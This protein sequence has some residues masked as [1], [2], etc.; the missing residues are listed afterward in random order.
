[1]KFNALF[2]KKASQ[3]SYTGS[4]ESP[5]N[6][7]KIA[8]DGNNMFWRSQENLKLVGSN[9]A[10]TEQGEGD[11]INK[12]E[13]VNASNSKLATNLNSAKK[14]SWKRIYQVAALNQKREECITRKRKPSKEEIR[15]LC[16]EFEYDDGAKILK[17]EEVADRSDVRT[18]KPTGRNE[19][20]KLECP[21]IEESTGGKKVANDI[22]VEAEGS[23]G[24]L[25][26]AWKVDI[27]VNLRS[28]SKS[29]IDVTLKEEGVKE[30]CRFTGFYGSPYVHKKNDSWSLLRNLGQQ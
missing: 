13:K 3:Y 26:L 9:E 12:D 29:H 8:V 7:A 19:N 14:T 15:V 25:C 1:M 5:L 20:L 30:E 23:R 2:K 24:L 22:D 21:W 17:H 28:F 16:T 4:S 11:T 18:G 10:P 27:S 6:Y